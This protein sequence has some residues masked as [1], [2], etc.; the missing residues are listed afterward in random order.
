MEGAEA[1]VAWGYQ[2]AAELGPWVLEMPPGGG[3]EWWLRAEVRSCDLFRLT[4]APL[5]FII[6]NSAAGKPPFERRLLDAQVAGGVL[7]GRLGP[8]K[9]T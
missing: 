8:R 4:Q 3:V 1:V 6:D 2:C 7:T 9:G 5:V